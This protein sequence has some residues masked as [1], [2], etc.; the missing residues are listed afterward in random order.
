MFVSISTL[1]TIFILGV[2]IYYWR[3]EIKGQE[4]DFKNSKQAEIRKNLP[5]YVDNS[6]LPYLEAQTA[7]YIEN[8]F[9]V[10]L[11]T[12][13]LS[14]ITKGVEA[15][16]NR[17]PE[18]R[19]YFVLYSLLN[20]LDKDDA[21]NMFNGMMALKSSGIFTYSEFLEYHRGMRDILVKRGIW[22]S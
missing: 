9:K 22:E 8:V 20:S 11:T 12:D 1:V 16:K 10:K 2:I 3:K 6:D 19:A 18:H 15:D 5:N 21:H 7:Y 4:D 14:M 13:I 17:E